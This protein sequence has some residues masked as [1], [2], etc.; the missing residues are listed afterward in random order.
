VLRAG[1][2]FRLGTRFEGWTQGGSY[3]H[4]YGDYGRSLA[5]SAFYQH[6]LR[7]NAAGEAAPF[8]SYSG[9]AEFAAAGRF[10]PPE[11]SPVAQLSN[12]AYGLHIDPERYRSMEREAVLARINELRALLNS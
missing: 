10:L 11:K 6:W 2:G 12:Y 9:A 4:G 3:I 5:A 1:S 8:D 7:A